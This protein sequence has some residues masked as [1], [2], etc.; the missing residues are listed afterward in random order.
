MEIALDFEL[1]TMRLD[2]GGTRTSG[3]DLGK[4]GIASCAL[5]IG[6]ALDGVSVV[7]GA[8]T[9]TLK[10][11]KSMI[12]GVGRVGIGP[13]GGGGDIGALPACLAL[14]GATLL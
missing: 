9:G 1:G 2:R 12:S 14:G 13:I 7:G 8:L 3:A 10:P 4:G 6:I 11:P 5:A